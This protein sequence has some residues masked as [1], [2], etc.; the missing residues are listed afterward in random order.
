M[1]F[2]STQTGGESRHDPFQFC[3]LCGEALEPFEQGDRQRKRCP[4][5]AW[6][7]YRNPTVGVAL[8]V[9]EGGRVLLGKRR[10]GGWCIPCGHVEW[11]EDIQT[12]A[13]REAFEELG[14]H[15]SLE[16]IFAVHSNFH[17]PDHHTVGIWFKTRID[18]IDALAAGGDLRALEF[19]SL[20]DLPRLAFPTD[21]IVLKKLQAEI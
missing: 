9:T 4:N 7:R 10:D 6:I 8:L 2:E 14:V 13:R 1:A 15:V 18:E 17:N 5:C 16:E 3:P 11:D 20:Q 19:F 12:A 21:R